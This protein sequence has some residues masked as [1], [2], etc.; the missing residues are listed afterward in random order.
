M[1]DFET[2][3]NTLLDGL[4]L[5]A[6][7]LNRAG[8]AN[9]VGMIREIINGSRCW[10]LEE[11]RTDYGCV[12]GEEKLYYGQVDTFLTSIAAS[13]KDPTRPSYAKRTAWE[14]D[15]DASC[16]SNRLAVRWSTLL[17]LMKK[18][19]FFPTLN[20]DR[21]AEQIGQYWPKDDEFVFEITDKIYETYQEEYFGSCMHGKVYPKWYD[22]NSDKVKVVRIM[23]RGSLLGRALLWTLDDG[24]GTYLDRV[25][26]SDL[27]AHTRAIRTWAERQGFI[28]KEY[29]NMSDEPEDYSVTLNESSHGY[30]YMDTFKYARNFGD[31]RLRLYTND[32]NYYDATFNNTDGEGFEPDYEYSCDRCGEGMNDYTTVYSSGDC[33]VWCENCASNNTVVVD[34]R[35]SARYGN[36]VHEDDVVELH[37]GRYALNEEVYCCEMT[38]EY[39][40]ESE[41]VT[42]I[43]G[44]YVS[45]DNVITLPTGDYVR[46]DKLEELCIVFCDD[47]HWRYVADLLD[48]KDIEHDSIWE[49]WFYDCMTKENLTIEQAIAR[50]AALISTE[51]E[52]A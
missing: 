23:R 48:E 44:N 13:E 15:G 6:D 31:G 10:G 42:D 9:D 5:V 1:T 52:V 38:G 45:V 46:S 24:K 22:D 16:S 34:A 39:Y 14:G 17:K 47:G 51:E 33:E 41:V 29:D 43:E 25:Y 35:D 21:A 8:M 49:V 32:S 40:M 18:L 26:P 4:E 2:R 37:N 3:R 12:Y 27:G 30:P 50:R 28:T 19:G 20:L 7:T 11:T 36:N